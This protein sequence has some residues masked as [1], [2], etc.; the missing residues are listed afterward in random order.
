M[1]S[2]TTTSVVTK[3]TQRR[4]LHHGSGLIKH[5]N[6]CLLPQAFFSLLL[7][8]AACSS[9]TV[10]AFVTTT[11]MNNV[12][13][14]ILRKSHQVLLPK[15]LAFVDPLLSS[16]TTSPPPETTMW[17]PYSSGGGSQGTPFLKEAEKSVQRT[18]SIGETDYLTFLAMTCRYAM[19]NLSRINKNKVAAMSKPYNWNLSTEENYRQT[20]KQTNNKRF[21]GPY[22][23]VR[24][25][26]DYSYHSRYTQSREALQDRIVDAVL[27]SA[28]TGSNARKNS[29]RRRLAPNQNGPSWILFTAGVMGVGKSYTTQKL[30]QEGKLPLGDAY[31]KVDP[32]EIRTMLPEYKTYV[33]QN[34]ET[35]GELTQKEAGM[36]SEIIIQTALD[37][38]INVLVDGSLSD[39]QWYARYF[40]TLRHSYTKLHIGI[41]HV[42]APIE[43]IINRIMTRAKETGRMIPQHV[44]LQN[45][46]SVPKSVQ[47]LKNHV[48]FFLQVVNNSNNQQHHHHHTAAE[49]SLP[50]G[51]AVDDYLQSTLAQAVP[52]RV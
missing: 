50:K 11:I 13:S 9:R 2:P 4:G 28:T 39:S 20:F 43:T 37:A 6:H 5:P 16:I 18:T 10:E 12:P 1:K 48:D 26:L 34:P 40:N 36:I 14:S 32:D 35:A 24:R 21:Y 3:N 27:N 7:I 19:L 46:E 52:I 38:G 22:H 17:A 33:S 29:R 31:V 51:Y 30:Q 23:Q 49:D 8:S 44:L 25:R 45:I 47:K 42:T 15:P 41:I